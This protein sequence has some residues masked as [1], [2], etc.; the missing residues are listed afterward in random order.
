MATST[1]TSDALTLANGVSVA[2]VQGKQF[3]PD[4]FGHIQAYA[5]WSVQVSGAATTLTGNIQFSLDGVNWVNSSAGSLTAPAGGG[6]ISNFQVALNSAAPYIRI[7]ITAI[8]GGSAT[9]VAV[10]VS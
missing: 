1:S 4:R 3:W 5:N 10:G 2:G 8:A 7:N 6:S 9:I